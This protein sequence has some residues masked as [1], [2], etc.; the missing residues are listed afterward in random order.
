MTAL[1]DLIV[2][3]YF[4]ALA[5]TFAVVLAENRCKRSLDDIL[6]DAFRAIREGRS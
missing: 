6:R 4:A 1:M 3:G 5:L 2:F